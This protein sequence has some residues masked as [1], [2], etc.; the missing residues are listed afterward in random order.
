MKKTLIFC[1]TVFLVFSMTGCFDVNNHKKKEL[2]SPV[3]IICYDSK[4]N[5][6]EGKI[7]N[8]YEYALNFDKLN[9]PAPVFNVYVF[10]VEL[11]NIYLLDIYFESKKEKKIEKL[12]LYDEYSNNVM[13]DQKVRYSDSYSIITLEI[14]ILEKMIYHEFFGWYD[15]EN[16]YSFSSKDTL[17]YGYLFVEKG[18]NESI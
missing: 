18:T 4:G 16:Y 7:S 13:I 14:N 11:N 5:I 8:R 12:S 10:E 6:I 3:K 17:F 2:M 9:S 15:G 1:L